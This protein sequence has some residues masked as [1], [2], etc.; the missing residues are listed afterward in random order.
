MMNKYYTTFLT[1]CF[2][3]LA[4]PLLAQQDLYH[5]RV[6]A[7]V[8]SMTYYGDLNTK[9]LPGELAPEQ[10][11]LGVAIE[12][13][14]S[15]DFSGKLLYTQGQ[16]RANDRTD[17][18]FLE[19]SLNAQTDIRDYSFLL[20][21]YLDNDRFLERKSF[22]SPYLSLGIGYTSFDVYGDLLDAQG[23]P[24][25]YWSDNTIR[26][27][28]EGAPG[29]GQATIVEQDGE[30]E[31]ELSG[32]Q[33]EQSYS[34]ETF[35][36]PIA[37]GLKFRLGDRINLN[38]E[39]MAR[40]TFTDYLDDVGGDYRS[41]YSNDLQQL[42]ANPT[43]REATQ[44]GDSPSINDFYTFTSVSLHYNFSRRDYVYRAPKIYATGDQVNLYTVPEERTEVVTRPDTV[45]SVDLEWN[46]LMSEEHTLSD[47]IRIVPTTVGTDT[48]LTVLQPRAIDTTAI[49]TLED[50]PPA[51][52]TLA[53]IDLPDTLMGVE[54]LM[55]L[56]DSLAISFDQ[57]SLQQDT[58]MHVVRYN[59]D[60]LGEKIALD[61]VATLNMAQPS[62]T[63]ARM[64]DSSTLVIS[65]RSGNT[66]RKLRITQP[67]TTQSMVR[68]P[69]MD[70]LAVVRVSD[71]T[72]VIPLSDSLSLSVQS[73]TAGT[74]SKVSV[75]QSKP[76]TVQEEVP[77]SP[78]V[79]TQATPNFDPRPTATDTTSN[80]PETGADTTSVLQETEVDSTTSVQESRISTVPRRTTPA[81]PPTR[82]D[83]TS[84]TPSANND[85]NTARLESQI[86]QLQRELQQLRAA[87]NA[88]RTPAPSQRS[89]NTPQNQTSRRA[90]TSSPSS[91]PATTTKPQA[92]TPK[93]STTP[94]T[95]SSTTTRTPTTTTSP[96]TSGTNPARVGVGVGADVAVVPAERAEQTEVADTVQLDS[97]NQRIDNFSSYLESVSQKND[98]SLANV[99]QE[100]RRLRAQLDS[101]QNTRNRP[102]TTQADSI[103]QQLRDLELQELR[104]SE[105][106]FKTASFSVSNSSKE[107]LQQTA[108]FIK[109]HPD[110]VVQLRGYTDAMGDPERN[111]ILSRKRA[112]AVKDVLVEYGVEPQKIT[113]RFFGADL[114]LDR[115]E[116]AY[117]RRVEVIIEE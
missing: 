1:G 52:D 96:T 85:S 45:A 80:L 9:I 60:S 109:A 23:M 56:S 40:Y 72:T 91:P 114:S 33:T 93:T 66:P 113:T 29:A 98:T 86:E 81:R 102:S 14:L 94:T 47:S 117:A 97:L 26:S 74:T 106:F 92:T 28:A 5:W 30:Y 11:G 48:F 44:R 53:N 110:V 4:A 35:N 70:T 6:G 34:T 21:Y 83:R 19:R 64:A 15:D 7:Y 79:S 73:D 41:E 63:L 107:R 36:I 108:S 69:L 88:Q 42:A 58:L 49:N 82:P 16:F 3:L 103:G 43:G 2:L 51:L 100:V 13:V 12:R 25:H 18:T 84:T 57:D 105:V 75:V 27:I 50:Q 90:T 59:L 115:S 76:D 65:P 101:M 39:V 77:S 89:A 32:L 55:P 61:T 54:A 10:L 20:T 8:G 62:D 46:A 112:Q 99:A 17:N 95:K 38:L 31:T 71:T 22:L 67:D 87:Q 24:Y 37:L 68:E 116:A 111:Q 104:T 78:V